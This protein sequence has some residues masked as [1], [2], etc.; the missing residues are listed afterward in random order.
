MLCSRAAARAATG[1]SRKDE[2]GIDHGQPSVGKRGPTA[3]VEL[4][5][6]VSR[7]CLKLQEPIDPS[8][9]RVEQRIKERD[10]EDASRGRVEDE[11]V[12]DPERCEVQIEAASI[13]FDAYIRHRQHP[14]GEAPR[15]SSG[16]VYALFRGSDR[17]PID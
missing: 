2:T 6:D 13:A 9:A 12:A 7:R 15:R 16:K 3:H 8:P 11:T 1:L 5:V 17:E 14:L 4:A 10:V